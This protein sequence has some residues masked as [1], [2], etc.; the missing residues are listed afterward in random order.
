MCVC[1][2]TWM[3]LYDH[4]YFL[5]QIRRSLGPKPSIIQ[6]VTTFKHDIW[7]KVYLK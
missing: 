5:L 6:S 4:G 7:P 2:D 1:I 3:W